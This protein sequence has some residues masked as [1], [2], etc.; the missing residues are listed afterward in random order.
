MLIP[1]LFPAVEVLWF[2]PLTGDS[3]SK[4]QSKRPNAGMPSTLID[5]SS[6]TTSDSVDECETAVCFLHSHVSG[7]NVRGPTNVKTAP[8][9]DFE[10]DKSSAKLASVYNANFKSSTLSP[11]KHVKTKWL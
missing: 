10:F 5:V 6:A 8:V 11:R 3:T 9:L 1:F 4:M 7:T 2:S